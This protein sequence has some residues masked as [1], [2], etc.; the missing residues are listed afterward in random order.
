MRERGDQTEWPL[1]A[2]C[3]T[4]AGDVE[5]LLASGKGNLV[6]EIKLVGAYAR[7]G[8]EHR[9]HVVIPA[10]AHFRLRP[11]G[12][13]AEVSR[14]DVGCQP[15]LEAVQLIRTAEMHLARQ[16]GAVTG[17]PQIVR[18]SQGLRRKFGGVIVGAY[19]RR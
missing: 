11:V 9:T 1:I 3:L 13:P 18:E 10:W 17:R 19:V 16:N 5:E 6:V 15:V 7:A 4:F 2:P 14:I 8:V 12:H